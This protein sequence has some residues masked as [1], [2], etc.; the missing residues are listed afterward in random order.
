MSE[1]L[2]I[3]RV[4]LCLLL[5]DDNRA[6]SQMLTKALAD[7]FQVV[8]AHTGA[9]ARRKLREFRPDLIV[10]ELMLPDVD[11][12]LLMIQLKAET[13]AP[14][15]VCTSRDDSVDRALSTRLGAVGFIPKP[16]NLSEFKTHL[17]DVLSA[18]RLPQ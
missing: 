7:R 16:I 18:R 11:G 17:T 1:R 10:L 14:M 8:P 4:E 5:I 6:L 13:D 2:S 12:L 15:V 3:D 9:E